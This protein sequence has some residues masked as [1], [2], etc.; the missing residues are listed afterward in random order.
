LR[1]SETFSWA[2]PIHP[3]IFFLPTTTRKTV[4]VTGSQL[5]VVTGSQLIV[6]ILQYYINVGN[7]KKS[8]IISIPKKNPVIL[9][10]LL[11]SLL[12]IGLLMDKKTCGERATA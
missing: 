8:P 6:V 1:F 11:V 3:D 7:H 2:V 4:D 12:L 5:I 9:I 10:G